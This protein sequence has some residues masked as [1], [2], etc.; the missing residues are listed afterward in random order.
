MNKIISLLLIFALIFSF[1]ACNKKANDESNEN[2]SADNG[3]SNGQNNTPTVPTIVV[4]EYKDYGRGSVNF[5]DISYSRP[6]LEAVISGFKTVADTVKANAVSITEQINALKELESAFSHTESMYALAEIYAHKDSSVEFWQSE[7]KYISTNYPAFTKSVEDLLVACAASEHRETFEKDYFGYSLKKYEDGGIYTDALVGLLA[8][9][10]SLEAEYS[11]LSTATVEITYKSV[12]GFTWEG[13]VDEVLQLAEEKYGKSSTEYKNATV[14]INNLYQQRLIAISTPIFVELIKTRRLIADELGYDS[15]T[16][17]AYRNMGYDRSGED[18]KEFLENVGRYV[19]PVAESLNSVTFLSYFQK[20][21]QPRV[22]TVTLIN[23]LYKVYSKDESFKNAYSYML[24]HGLYDI[25]AEAQNRYE[26]AFTAYIDKNN[27]PYVFVSTEGFVKDY[28][29]LSHEFGHFY[30]GYINFGEES[31]LDLAEVSSQALEL[32]SILRLKNNLKSAD[33]EYLEYFTIYT[34]LN[35]VLL[36]QSFYAMFEHMA[37]SLEYDKINANNLK[38]VAQKAFSAIFGSDLA[39]GV[40]ALQYVIIPHTILYPH[41]VESYVVSAI[42]SLEMFFMESYRTGTAGEGLEV[43][44]QL[45]DR[46]SSS[47][48]F[49]EAIAEAGLSSPF[50]P[51]TVKE[52]ANLIHYQILGKYY[53]NSS[54]SEIGAA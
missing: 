41:Y 29:T 25:A 23:T 18:M 39:P 54:D 5:S 10:A 15:Y 11:S 28:N 9:E 22:D 43:Y 32:I 26:G 49:D 53:Y 35:S 34:M 48:S 30:D 13:T 38:T 45:V 40:N 47:I 12:G 27:S 14:A 44:K 7:F 51:K 17:F 52:I 50:E 6:N 2:V 46:A 20:N 42:P 31:S 33:Y 8:D 16:E 1:A 21:N 4:P 37:Y 24:Q 36:E 19:S 3:A